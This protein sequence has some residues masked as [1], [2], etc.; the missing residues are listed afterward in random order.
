MRQMATGSDDRSKTEGLAP[1]DAVPLEPVQLEVSEGPDLGKHFLLAAG[2]AVLGAAPECDLVLS[3]TAVSRTHAR[4]ELLGGA[5]RVV[6]LGS[7]N[8]TT[9]LGARLSDAIVPIGGAI[10]VGRTTVR[11]RSSQRDADV[12]AFTELHGLY[13]Q[14]LAMRRLFGRLQRVAQTQSVVLLEGETGTGKDAAAQAIHR[15]SPRA[16]KP[17]GVVDCTTLAATLAESELFGHV[18]GAFTGADKHRLGAVETAASGTLFL[19]EIGDLPLALQPKLLRLLEAREF[20]R[21]GES[22]PVPSDVRVIAAT[23]KPLQA[24]V[25]AGTFRRDLY[26]RLAVVVLQVPPLR[27]RREDIPELAR[28]FARSLTGVELELSPGILS[29]LEAHDWPGNVRELRNTVERVVNLGEHE[30]GLGAAAATKPIAASGFHAQR[31]ELMAQFE[32]DYVRSLLKAHGDNLVEAAR[33]AGVSRS[34]LYKLLE[35]HG[36]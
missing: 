31:E 22:T 14:S 29:M 19:D 36:L 21:V 25:E 4:V 18:K 34:F 24:Q 20:R 35:R 33:V 26:F 11:V 28:R 16:D 30:A 9:Y 15:A 8:G 12:P 23:H 27:E 6:D 5:V 1:Q 3:D 13:G 17:W 7:R 10:R 32:R 2:T